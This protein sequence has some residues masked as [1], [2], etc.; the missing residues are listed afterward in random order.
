MHLAWTHLPHALHNTELDITRVPHT[1]Q[2]SIL[3][4]KASSSIPLTINFVY[5]RLTQIGPDGKKKTNPKTDAIPTS[6]F[7]VANKYSMSKRALT[8]HAGAFTTINGKNL[9]G[10][11]LSVNTTPRR[12]TT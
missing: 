9:E 2:G 12:K 6:A 1:P 5:P 11:N 8:E 3:L 10:L 7:F 4:L